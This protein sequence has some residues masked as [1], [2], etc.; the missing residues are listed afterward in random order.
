DSRALA[1]LSMGGFQAIEIGLNHLDTFAWVGVFSAGLR[2]GFV[3]EADLTALRTD[4]H[5]AASRLKLLSVRIGKKDFLL[6]DARR[7]NHYLEQKAV[8]HLYQEVEGSH[9]WPVWQQA[10]TDLAPRLFKAS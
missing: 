5:Q 8:P 4:S 7:F 9:E 10:L 1:G 6:R 3:T 2:E